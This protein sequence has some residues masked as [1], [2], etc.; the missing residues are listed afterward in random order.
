M[1]GWL[2]DTFVSVSLLMVAV[3]ALRRPVARLFGAGW[4]YALWLVP[5]LRLVLPPLSQALPPVVIFIPAT[6]G[7]T[8]PLPA[9]A[10]P[11][12]W[13]PL[14]LATW[15]GGAVIFLILQWLAYRAFLRRLDASARAARP[16]AYGGIA[17]FVSEAA[18]GPLALGLLRRRIVLP[19]DF[20]RRYSEAE[21][22]LAMEHELT[23]HRHGDIWW[24]MAALAMLAANW[25]NPLAWIAFRAFRTDQ[26]LA[27]DAAVA[28]R[29]TAGER[30]DYARALV[31]SA[32]TPG[33]IAACPMTRAGALKLRLRMMG[34]HRATPLRSA[35]GG[36]AVATLGMA[37]LSLAAVLAEPEPQVVLSPT[38]VAVAAVA[39]PAAVPHAVA[40]GAIAAP[41]PR[42]RVAAALRVR[43]GAGLAPRE[44]P[45]LL[46]AAVEP[47]LAPLMPQPV[48]LP[49]FRFASVAPRVAAAAPMAEIH[50]RVMVIH[51]ASGEV[52]RETMRFAVAE[53]IAHA[54][55]PEMAVRLA[56]L[57]Q[58]LGGRL[59]TKVSTIITTRQGD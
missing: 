26:E 35:G 44:K 34:S 1:T 49:Q 55:S 32:T 33:L 23:H 2:F 15:A 53:A 37:G 6:G 40:G 28:A 30:L 22:R 24:N 59:W 54:D 7:G 50:A 3:L 51:T 31:K 36:A 14:L 17:T 13:L 38:T 46:L 52:T 18:D 8:A 16:P 5:P 20:S 39:E 19:P 21:R 56:R 58:A 47:K 4:A 10:G 43:H 9:D 45:S 12:Q 27:C 29:A 48:R 11:G 42:M 57:D 25:W 41:A